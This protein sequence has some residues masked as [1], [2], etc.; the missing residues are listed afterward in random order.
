MNFVA[1]D[2]M[3]TGIDY[4]GEA[5]WPQRSAGCGCLD[6]C[7]FWKKMHSNFYKSVWNQN[8][9]ICISV[10][11]LEFKTGKGNGVACH[12]LYELRGC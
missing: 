9:K 5:N 1:G 7:G 2:Y 4:L 6:T 3:W 8:G 11:A 12:L 10:S